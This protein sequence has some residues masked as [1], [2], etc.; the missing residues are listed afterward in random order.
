M[1]TARHKS[2]KPLNP[3]LGA[4]KRYVRKAIDGAGYEYC[5]KQE[6]SPYDREQG[7]CDASDL[8]PA[9]CAAADALRGYVF[10]YVDWPL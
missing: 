3:K 2:S 9:L 5:I 4:E 6:R 7:T 8:S 1:I 10:A